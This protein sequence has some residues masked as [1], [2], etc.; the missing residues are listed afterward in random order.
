M[1]S[2]SN[3]SII[4]YC[5]ER[6]MTHGQTITEMKSSETYHNVYRVLV[7]ISG[8]SFSRLDGVTAGPKYSQSEISSAVIQDVSELIRKDQKQDVQEYILSWVLVNLLF[9][10]SRQTI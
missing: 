2:A 7:Y 5:V 4:E 6:G 10:E 9:S 1:D 8:I 3:R